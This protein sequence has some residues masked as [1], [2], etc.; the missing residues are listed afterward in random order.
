V[1]D[2]A[3]SDS[4]VM[5][6]MVANDVSKMVVG[7][8]AGYCAISVLAIGAFPMEASIVTVFLFAGIHN[9]MEF[10]Y[11]VGRMPL[12][13]GRSRLYY[14]VGLGGVALL[15]MAYLL[16][17]VGSG[18][19]LWSN[20]EWS[21]FVS[22]W[23]SALVAWVF[24]L[25]SLRRPKCRE[26]PDWWL[27]LSLACLAGAMSWLTPQLSSLALVYLHP[28]IAMWFLGKQIRRSKRSW[29]KT[30]RL[31]FCAVPVSVLV[32]AFL[33]ARS[34]NLPEDTNLFWRITQ[35]AGSE[36]FP[37]VS[38]RLLV[39]V[40]V[41]LETI[42]YFVWV[43]LIPLVDPRAIPW[44]MKEIPLLVN[45]RGLPKFIGTVL[46]VGTLL[47]LGLWVG[48]AIDYTTTRDIYFAIAIL[49]VLAEFPF[50]IRML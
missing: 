33:L 39:S 40:H 31:C 25:Y 20:R 42:H 48:F 22:W 43:L 28:F 10:R 47:V 1:T 21:V 46:V 18:N 2:G 23:N 8:F 11:F 5:P 29:I 13:W 34:P 35:H 36:I 30:Y 6:R 3:M 9:W 15:A 38:S 24:L 14:T 7:L 49:H 17:F 4:T 41:F 26:K 37:E 32:L 44:R 50:L 45:P 19:W 27:G 16:A 12:R